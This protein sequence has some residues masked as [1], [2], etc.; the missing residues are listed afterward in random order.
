MPSPFLKAKAP[1]ISR[2]FEKDMVK[3]QKNNG[4]DVKAKAKAKDNL[5]LTKK[6][7]PI[8]KSKSIKTAKDDSSPEVLKI[9]HE[10]SRKNMNKDD[11]TPALEKF[12][13]KEQKIAK[14][15]SNLII[16]AEKFRK[17]DVKKLKGN[18]LNQCANEVNNFFENAI[19]MLD[20][21]D[22]ILKPLETIMEFVKTLSGDADVEKMQLQPNV[23]SKIMNAIKQIRT[24]TK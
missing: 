24:L 2:I 15:D 23:E 1:K 19:D 10:N 6:P 22:P 16:R 14:D 3:A 18:E 7:K 17:I 5:S 13:E 12:K 11:I 8:V 9:Q 20:K 4:K 21:T